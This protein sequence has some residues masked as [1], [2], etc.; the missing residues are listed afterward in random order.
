MA[1]NLQKNFSG[2]STTY[3]Q[4]HES[5]YTIIEA[6]INDLLL[7]LGSTNGG[8]LA[9]PAGLEEIFDRDGIIGFGSFLIPTGN[10]G[11]FLLGVAPGAAW[12]G[13]SFRKNDASQTVDLTGLPDGTLYLDV[14]TNG[15]ASVGTTQNANTV[16]SFT[17]ASG[18]TTVSNRTTIVDILFD[19]DDY[20]DQLTSTTLATNYTSTAN[21]LEDIE[22]RL[23][24]L[25]SFYMQDANTTS[26]LFFGLKAGR[27]R[28][29]VTIS[30][31]ASQTI[32]LPPSTAN[33]YIEVNPTTGVVS[34]NTSGFTSNFIPLFRV[35]TTIGIDVV[36]DKRT[37]ASL[38]GG[39]GGGGHAQNTD[40]G[41]SSLRFDVGLTQATGS[42]NAAFG[43]KRGSDPTV[44]IRW[45]ETSN[46]WE[47]T[48]D[49]STYTP[50]G[51][52]DLG[53]QELSRFVSIEN[54]PVVLVQNN[55]STSASYA[56][57][58]ITSASELIDAQ[59][60]GVSGLVLRVQY[61]DSGA[62]LTTN[63]KFREP[64]NAAVSPA[65]AYN[66][67][68]GLTGDPNER[69]L[70]TI[71]MEGQ[72]VDGSN[73]I[74]IGFEWFATASGPAT[75]NIV[76]FL[77]GYFAK[78]SG[79]GTQDRDFISASNTVPA[80]TQTNFD[81]TSFVNRGLVHKFTI[82]ETTGNPA[83]GYDLKLFGSDSFAS[84]TLLYQVDAISPA[85]PYT[86]S[87]PFWVEDVDLTS[88]LH[89]QINNTDGG[90]AGVYSV[91]IDLEQFA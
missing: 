38:G 5:N 59:T 62:S 57:V 41:T 84:S 66:V 91:T 40:I 17:W 1:I 58:D 20:N 32:L 12:V 75:A 82:E 24:V 39:G 27:V 69:Q 79:V 15:T 26:G 45:N 35:T 77:V 72:G 18:S 89:M 10:I 68:A 7:T 47:F 2:G 16:R 85:T 76:V 43:V 73:T 48:N 78:V 50:I 70:S 30:D 46:Q 6:S 28:N 80:A 36:D 56:L 8:P 61:W 14:S 3:I 88:E 29:D 23:G 55:I 64:V 4:D 33:N 65:T 87:L 11:G 86:D 37:W 31:T 60:F 54:P 67:Q 44:E 90:N 74:H 13:A 52:L 63:V 19:G 83:A 51:N 53:V 9:V 22:S 25:G 21:R 49:G 71:I 34:T 42:A 81:L